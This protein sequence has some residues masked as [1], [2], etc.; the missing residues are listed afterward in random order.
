MPFVSVSTVCVSSKG[1][2]VQYCEFNRK[3]MCV[4]EIIAGLTLIRSENR[5]LITLV[6]DDDRAQICSGD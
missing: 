2:E 1:K 5:L 6:S 4:H 3:L